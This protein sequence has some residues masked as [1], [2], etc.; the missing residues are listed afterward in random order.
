MERI[1][2]HLV[3]MSIT[4]GWLILA[5][6]LVR[7]IF[8]K[9][10]K[11]FRCV[12]WALVALRLVCPWS[13]ESD[14]SIIPEKQIISE[15]FKSFNTVN[16]EKGNESGYDSNSESDNVIGGAEINISNGD[17]NVKGNGEYINSDIKKEDVTE[18]VVASW[19]AISI[20]ICTLKN[21]WMVGVAIMGIYYVTSYIILK[22]KVKARI[23]YE[24]NIFLCDNIPS[25]FILGIISPRIYVPSHLS[26]NELANIIRHE[27]AHLSRHDNWWKPIGFC[28]LSVYWFN[29]LIWVAY[30]LF[31]KD[32]ELACD[33]RVIKG[34]NVLEIK[35]YSNTLLECSISRKLIVAAPLAFGEVAVKTRIKSV[36]NYKKPTFWVIIVSVVISVVI[37]IGFMTNPVS[38]DIKKLS[39]EAGTSNEADSNN[40]IE[41]NDAIDNVEIDKFIS[42]AILKKYAELE[43]FHK[44]DSF[45]SHRIIDVEEKDGKEIFYM[46]VLYRGYVYEDGLAKMITGVVIP[47]VITV[48]VDKEG[49][50][51]LEEYWEP[52]D[53]SLYA[54]DIRDKFPDNLEDE[55]FDSELYVE[56]LSS[57]C[58]EK[59]KEYFIENYGE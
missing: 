9:L 47:T 49:R 45:E 20:S 1:F 48:R 17:E 11:I 46:Y 38:N 57:D 4:A 52:R 44:C 15:N 53:G 24:N 21:I 14:M 19:S 22:L 39:N 16:V 12:L 31:C 32:V 30:F 40:T 33:E 59:A 18:E 29:P 54:S 6:L 25:A 43:N 56:Q 13:I 7:C 28:L 34:M 41:S 8:N 58:D 10:P 37:A 3:N 23:P 36:L 2:L 26:E 5:V 51:V 42:E 27:R 35:E 55:I 50:Y